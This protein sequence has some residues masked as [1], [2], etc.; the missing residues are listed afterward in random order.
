MEGLSPGAR[1]AC[2]RED[3]C[4]ALTLSSPRGRSSPRQP[5]PLGLIQFVVQVF[6]DVCMF[7]AFSVFLILLHIFE[8]SPYERGL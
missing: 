5:G 1:P 7:S 2:P 6:S 3:L 8:A 4:E